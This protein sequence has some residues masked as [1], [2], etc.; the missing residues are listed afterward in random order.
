[1]RDGESAGWSVLREIPA[2][3]FSLVP[4]ATNATYVEQQSDGLRL[5]HRLGH[6]VLTLDSY[7]LVRRAADGELLGD[8]GSDAVKLE[9]S[10]FGNALRTT[11]AHR[12]L[13]VDPSGRGDFVRID[14]AVITREEAKA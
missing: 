3:E 13:V 9:L 10:A 8:A 12:V 7:E 1:M 4:L 5:S 11:P 14:D 2:E 6:L